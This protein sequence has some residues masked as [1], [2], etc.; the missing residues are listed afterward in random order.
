M[1]HAWWKPAKCNDCR[2]FE[3]RWRWISLFK[4]QSGS[5][6]SHLE[7][8]AEHEENSLNGFYVISGNE[9]DVYRPG[10]YDI[11]FSLFD[12]HGTKYSANYRSHGYFYESIYFT[13]VI[14]RVMLCGNLQTC[15]E[16]VC[17]ASKPTYFMQSNGR[18]ET[19]FQLF[20]V[21]GEHPGR[22]RS[23]LL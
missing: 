6:E 16:L 19:S 15:C 22:E 21:T 20:I 1:W 5:H 10:F 13:N 11:L 3:K 23:E 18:T 4:L 7:E 2:Q 14:I 12:I 8:F 17:K 9:S